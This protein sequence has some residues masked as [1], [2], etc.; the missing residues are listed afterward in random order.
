M[1]KSIIYVTK[2][3][4]AIKEFTQDYNKQKNLFNSKITKLKLAL[5]P[6]PPSPLL[7]A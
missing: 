6:P 4:N 7:S 5:K 1:D 2:L 3:R